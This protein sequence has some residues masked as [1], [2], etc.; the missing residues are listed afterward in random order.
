MPPES[1]AGAGNPAA[2]SHRD[3]LSAADRAR[4]TQCFNRGTQSLP[5]NADY[6]LEMYTACVLGDPGNA[7]YVQAFFGALKRKFGT[8]KG[9]GLASLWSAGSRVA[10][11]KHAAAAQWRELIRH[12]VGILKSNPTDSQCLLAVAEACG[13]LQLVESQGVFLKAA[14]DAAPNDAEVNRQCARF[15]ASQG[16]FDQAIACWVRI[17]GQKGLGEEAQR[18]IARLQVE[19]T[20]VVGQGMSGRPTVAGGA[21]RPGAGQ[22]PAPADRAAELRAEI[23]KNPAAVDA[24]LELADIIAR[25]A[26]IDEAEA[27]LARTLA[28]AGG[29]IKVREH[30]EDRQIRWAKQRVVVAERRAEADPS[31]ENRGLVERLKAAQVKAEIDVYSARCSRYPENLTWKYELA[32]RLKQ[33][34]NYT[35]AIRSFQEVLQDLRRRGPV[36]LE[37]GECFQKIKQYQLAMKN[38]ETAVELLTDRE[39]ELR[40]RALYRAGVLASG[41]NDPDAAHKHLGA[42]AALDFGYRDVAERL[43]K[44]GPVKDKGGKPEG[45]RKG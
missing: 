40:K 8:R 16:Q 27:L 38:Y 19:K 21:A 33:V 28:A 14:L 37:L 4:L 45:D 13:N 32:L 22:Q 39:M 24:A 1:T 41:L 10:L 18:E 30:V 23:A 11:K 15:A 20:I 12:G 44:L 7:V 43:D 36:S 26:T 3:P 5:T 42:L 31:A 25:D 34:G 6:A 2:S 17:S 35:E 9:G 29:D